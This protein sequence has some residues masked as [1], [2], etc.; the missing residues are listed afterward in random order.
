[1]AFTKPRKQASLKCVWQLI[2]GAITYIVDNILAI[3]CYFAEILMR[4][5]VHRIVHQYNNNYIDLHQ[6]SKTKN[7]LKKGD[8]SVKICCTALACIVGS[9]VFM[10]WLTG[11]SLEIFY[12][13][14]KGG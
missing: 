1:M 14:S 11:V 10:I 13:G 9:I 2:N 5:I 3:V 8:I 6:G 7:E 12:F 4:L